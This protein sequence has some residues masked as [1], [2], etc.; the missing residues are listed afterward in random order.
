[1][2]W[3]KSGFSNS[4]A[5][6]EIFGSSEFMQNIEKGIANINEN[7]AD[8]S[9]AMVVGWRD[10]FKEKNFKKITID[11][12]RTAAKEPDIASALHIKA[13]NEVLKKFSEVILNKDNFAK[14]SAEVE[15]KI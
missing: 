13:D 10:L 8:I 6:E 7:F 15:K 14:M 2:E 9:D 1:M 12:F 11:E 3:M 4:A 5:F